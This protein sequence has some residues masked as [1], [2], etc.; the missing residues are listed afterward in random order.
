MLMNRGLN[1]MV[2]IFKRKKDILIIV[3]ICVIIICAIKTYCDTNLTL[4]SVAFENRTY[5]FYPECIRY[6]VKANGY[7][8]KLK[9]DADNNL[10]VYAAPGP[11]RE[12]QP[13]NAKMQGYGNYV[14]KEDTTLFDFIN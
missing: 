10:Y 4:K 5:Y 7:D 12:L 11:G 8:K 2:N 14:F 3:S 1:I 13:T 9:D 6:H